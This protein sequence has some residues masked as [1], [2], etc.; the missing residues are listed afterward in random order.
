MSYE[1]V[2][3]TEGRNLLSASTTTDAGKQQIPQ[4]LSAVSE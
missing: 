1:F 2:I 3:P 4:R